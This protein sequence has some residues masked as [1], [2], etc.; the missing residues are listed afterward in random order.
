M[1]SVLKRNYIKLQPGT[2]IAK[3]QNR[4]YLGRIASCGTDIA[5]RAQSVKGRII[6][7]CSILSIVHCVELSLRTCTERRKKKKREVAGHA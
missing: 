7:K 2:W 5:E 3:I 1:S 6:F 4:L